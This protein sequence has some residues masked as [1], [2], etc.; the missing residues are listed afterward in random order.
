MGDRPD[1][2]ARP[3]YCCGRSS[4][5]LHA[6]C[7]LP[8]IDLGCSPRLGWRAI[9]GAWA[10]SFIAR[11]NQLP[12]PV[13]CSTGARGRECD[14]WVAALPC[15]ECASSRAE[16]MFVHAAESDDNTGDAASSE[17]NRIREDDISQLFGIR[18]RE[19][20]RSRIPSTGGETAHPSCYQHSG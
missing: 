7:T 3:G 13:A 18:S 9:C 8:R 20:L 19:R 11:G 14:H 5:P 15:G 16:K 1:A 2:S 17:K 6:G 4:P 10:S 12:T